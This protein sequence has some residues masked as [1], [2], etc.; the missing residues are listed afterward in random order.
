MFPLHRQSLPASK[1]EL[2]AALEEALRGFVQKTG[3][4]VDVR[5][6]VWPYIDEV[7]LNLDGAN[8]NAPFPAPATSC[9]ASQ[10][11]FEIELVRVSARNARAYGLRFDL[12]GEARGVFLDRATDERGMLNLILRSAR[13]G[14]LTVSF[15]QL[16][17][18]EAVTRIASDQARQ[19]GVTIEQVRLALRQRSARSVAAEVRI[20]ARKFIRAKIDI[21]GQVDLDDD[22]VARV[23]QLRCQGSG[24]IATRVCSALQPHLDRF[25]DRSFALK[26]LPLGDSELKN[27]ELAV[28]DTVQLRL[29]LGPKV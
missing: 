24:A 25:N 13:E 10:H 20:Q 23:S 29:S 1:D 9:D 27:L 3:P 28:A 21:Y 16:D 5:S 18:E 19:R 6:R 22:F 4:I 14:E 11:A 17:L 15:A 2:A 8:F 26:S 12:Q 7:L